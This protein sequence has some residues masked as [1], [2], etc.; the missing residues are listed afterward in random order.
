MSFKGFINLYLQRL[1]NKQNIEV[2]IGQN[3]IQSDELEG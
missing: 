2:K 3:K 1:L